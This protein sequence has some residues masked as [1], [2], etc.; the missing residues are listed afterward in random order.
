VESKGHLKAWAGS[1]VA[2]VWGE[3][4]VRGASEFMGIVTC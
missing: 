2:G 3:Q 1:Q 4:V